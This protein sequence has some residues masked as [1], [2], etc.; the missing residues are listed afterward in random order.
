MGHK[1]VIHRATNPGRLCIGKRVRV[2]YKG[3]KVI[4]TNYDL[5]KKERRWE[6]RK[7]PK[8]SQA[9]QLG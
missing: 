8:R 6:G 3:E 4:E 1:R 5:R 7:T 9:E 2:E